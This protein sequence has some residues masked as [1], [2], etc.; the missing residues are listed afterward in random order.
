M[1]IEGDALNVQLT[2]LRHDVA[3]FLQIFSIKHFKIS[4][5]ESRLCFHF[6]AVHF[7]DQVM[8]KVDSIIGINDLAETW[9]IAEKISP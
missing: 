8:P 5:M 4:L 1:G 9:A 3:R 6:Q 7:P 2:G